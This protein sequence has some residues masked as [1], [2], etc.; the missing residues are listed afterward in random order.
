MSM[1]YI[2]VKEKTC[3]KSVQNPSCVGL[4]LTNNTMAFQN[5]TTV[6]TSL[7]DFHKLF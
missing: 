1:I 7:S 6:F 2:T 5:A 3:C 4:I